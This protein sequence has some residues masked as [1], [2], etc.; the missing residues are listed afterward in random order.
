[1]PMI[2]R[3]PHSAVRAA[4]AACA[5]ATLHGCGGTTDPAAQF[6]NVTFTSSIFALNGTPLGVPTAI[7]TATAATV[8]TE[9]T[10]DFDVA[11][12]LDQAGSVVVYTQRRVGRPIGITGHAVSLQLAGVPFDAVV[13][14]PRSGWVADSLLTVDPGDVFMVRAQNIACQF[15]FGTNLYSKMVVDS[16]N[17]A[18]R[19]IWVTTLA[20]PNCGFRELIPGRPRF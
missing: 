10:Y 15:A 19:R 17:V 6:E 8:R 18:S 14:A 7:N 20:D 9:E 2:A 5:V 11:F 3:R 12:D 1:M 4:L 16:I 13:S